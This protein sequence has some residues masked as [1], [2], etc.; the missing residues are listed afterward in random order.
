MSYRLIYWASLKLMIQKY[1]RF[2]VVK[3]KFI[4]ILFLF[5]SKG[6]SMPEDVLFSLWST[7]R[8]EQVW[9]KWKWNALLYYYYSFEYGKKKPISLFLIILLNLHCVNEYSFGRAYRKLTAHDW[10]L[11]FSS[12]ASKRNSAN[13]LMHV[14]LCISF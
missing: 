12:S 3:T 9:Y 14:F 11:Q 7:N 5:L 4:Y 6:L 10:L 8:I 1:C 2:I 13:T